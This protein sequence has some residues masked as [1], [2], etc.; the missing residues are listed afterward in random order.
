MATSKLPLRIG[1]GYDAHRFGPGDHVW[2]GGV[3]LPHS[4]GIVAHSDGDVLIHAISDAL[5]GAVG[6]GDIGQ[7]FPDTDARWA[8]LA[9]HT[10]LI[11]MREL[12]AEQGYAPAQ[13]DATLVAQAPRVAAV[14]P[15]MRAAIAAPL[16]LDIGQVNV[17]ATTTEKMGWVGQK[18]GLAAHAVALIAVV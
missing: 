3:K 4:H 16:G 7:H 11:R 2:L 18:E 9:G 13:L 15:D 10:M 5:L 14:I 8:N 17:K 12:L 1:H 6:L